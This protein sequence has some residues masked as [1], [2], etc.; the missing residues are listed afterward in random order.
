MFRLLYEKFRN[1]SRPEFCFS[2]FPIRCLLRSVTC[3]D[4]LEIVPGVVRF[5][6]RRG[7]C[8]IRSLLSGTLIDRIFVAC[9]RRSP[10]SLRAE[11]VQSQLELA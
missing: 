6:A 1:R 3:T 7:I 9:L 2:G 4:T 11:E 8:L 10:R 5:Q